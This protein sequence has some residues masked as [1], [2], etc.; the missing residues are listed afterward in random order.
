[1]ISKILKNS[2]N[3]EERYNRLPFDDYFISKTK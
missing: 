2:E 3:S 1:M